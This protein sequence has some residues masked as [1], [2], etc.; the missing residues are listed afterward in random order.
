MRIA[1]ELLLLSKLST[2]ASFALPWQ[3]QVEMHT[4]FFT[5]T[6]TRR[7]SAKMRVG[8]T[9]KPVGGNMGSPGWPRLEFFNRIFVP[10]TLIHSGAVKK[11]VSCGEGARLS[12][13]G[14]AWSPPIH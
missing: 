11:Q 8:S 7:A 13:V 2:A 14:E 4:A 3:G 5:A 10:A 6:I 12:W 1:P 9:A